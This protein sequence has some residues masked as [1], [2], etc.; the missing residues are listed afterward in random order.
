ML[1]PGLESISI[2]KGLLFTGS[3]GAYRYASSV[4]AGHIDMQSGSAQVWATCISIWVWGG[5][6]CDFRICHLSDI[7][8][9]I[10][11]MKYKKSLINYQN[12][13][14]LILPSLSSPGR[15]SHSLSSLSSLSRFYL[16]LDLK[17]QI[18][19]LGFLVFTTIE[20]Q[21]KLYAPVYF[22]SPLV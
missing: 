9:R 18:R 4:R 14:T 22:V 17:T 5:V 19:V 12:P 15:H 10:F 11:G 20:E 2:C 21:L 7:Y 16:S 1:A 13:T 6:C 3:R 8:N